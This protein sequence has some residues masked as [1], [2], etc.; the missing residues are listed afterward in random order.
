MPQKSAPAPRRPASGVQEAI[1][2]ITSQNVESILSDEDRRRRETPWVYR[3]VARIAGICGTVSFL[4]AHVVF[5]A[6]WIVLNLGGSG[7]DPY[8][9]TFLL[10][11]VSIE[12]IFLSIMVLI[13]QNL[14]SVENER[15]HHLDLQINLLNERETTAIM[16]LLTELANHAGV[17]SE[18]QEEVRSFAHDTDPEAVLGQIAAA[19][20]SHQRAAP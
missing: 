12:A 18:R 7:F 20:A 9:Y 5:F 17:P 15:R 19:E 2:H 4:L 8:P 10:F 14:A 6:G 3:L 1:E 16:R 13:S 11:G